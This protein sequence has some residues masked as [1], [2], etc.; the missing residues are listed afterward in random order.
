MW[1]PSCLPPPHPAAHPA[2]GASV[3]SPA[4][5]IEALL[6]RAADYESLADIDPLEA[7]RREADPLSQLDLGPFLQQWWRQLAA[8]QPALVQALGAQL[9][10][11]Q[12]AA[13]QP[14][15]AQA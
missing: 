12:A 10:P 6:E 4:A 11:T 1:A 3:N 14:V 2:E 5:G 15:F 13:L 9:T 7:R 8:A